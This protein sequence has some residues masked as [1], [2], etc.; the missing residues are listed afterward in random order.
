MIVDAFAGPGGWSEALKALGRSE[1]GIE[2]DAS[3][4]ATRAAAGHLTIRQD[5]TT[6]DTARFRPLEGLIASPPCPT[7]S[8]AG[9]RAGIAELWYLI[10]H[11]HAC[12]TGWRPYAPPADL[13]H[14]WLVGVDDPTEEIGIPILPD[15]RSALVLEPL[16]FALEC[17]PQWIALEQVPDVL[18]V[19]Q[20]MAYVFRAH[21][22]SVWCGILNAADF[23]VPQTRRRA[24]LKFYGNEFHGRGCEGGRFQI[25]SVDLFY[26]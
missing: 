26:P 5:V 11:V 25:C 3:A 20:A 10:E 13:G 6:V 22:Y 1:V 24:I 9:G 19:W 15:P 21:G 7:F 14:E 16:R 2:H 12:V 8:S 4:C 17:V 23:G 18:P